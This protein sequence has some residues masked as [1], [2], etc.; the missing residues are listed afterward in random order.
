MLLIRNGE[1]VVKSS[2]DASDDAFVLTEFSQTTLPVINGHRIK[3]LKQDEGS[4]DWG[5][6][7]SDQNRRQKRQGKM[8]D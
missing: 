6:V 2:S 5:K 1:D 7:W 8:V 4:S 3:A